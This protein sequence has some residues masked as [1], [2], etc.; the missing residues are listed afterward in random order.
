MGITLHAAF[1]PSC[2]QLLASVS[3]LVGKAEAFC[4]E[5]G[6]PPADILDAR[7]AGDMY[8]FAY[9]VKSTVVH[10]VGAIDGVR[11]GRF[12]PDT[13][14]LPDNFADLKALVNEAIDTL[15]TIDPDEM[16][17]FIGRDMR[18]VFGD[19]HLDFTGDQFLLSFAQPNFYFHA[20]TVYDILRW[21]GL[22]IGKRDFNGRVRVKAKA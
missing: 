11:R 21:K 20:A 22:A 19:N 10:S 16:E 12:S 9:Q 7:L 2:Q 8:P 14:P 6:L 15:A 13:R 17:G 5:G 18:F 4:A 1:V 3:R